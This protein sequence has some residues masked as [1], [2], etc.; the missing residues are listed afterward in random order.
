MIVIPA[1]DL[2]DG[3]CVQLVGGSYDREKIRLDD[4][5]AVADHWEKAGFRRLHV[6]D[7]D[8]ATARGSNTEVIRRILESRRSVVQVGGGIR[9]LEQ[10]T[11]LIS[12]GVERVVLGT[13]ALNE[14]AWAKEV[15]MIH[16]K[17]VIVA[18]DIRDGEILTRGWT[19]THQRS[20]EEVLDSLAGLPL[21]G[22]L[23]TAVHLEGLM[24]G[25]DLEL[26]KR[27]VE[28]TKFA[29]YA[30][31]GIGTMDDLRALATT[32]V[33][34]VVVGMALYTGALNPVEILAEFGR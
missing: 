1:L 25:T 28:K 16:P 2:R 12:A 5:V 32:G 23:V 22:L 15:A 6:V 4:P 3:K 8:A 13:R 17:R 9:K 10:I 21:H 27:V 31:G 7:L 24:E 18:I 33:A 34:G 30:S 19:G 26:M 11:R 20:L 29:V 14:P